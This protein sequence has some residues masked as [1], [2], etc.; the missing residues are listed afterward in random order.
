MKQAGPLHGGSKYDVDNCER[1]QELPSEAHQLIET[2]AWQRS[3]QPDI[4]EQEEH[5]LTEEVK[6]PKPRQLMHK[7][8]IPS[9]EKERGRQHRNREHVDVL[10]QKEERKL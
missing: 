6:D 5:D 9:A 4:E 3:A 10:G 1:H 2:K 8:P 7:R